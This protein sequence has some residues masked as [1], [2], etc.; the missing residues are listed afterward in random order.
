MGTPSRGCVPSYILE[1]ET[2][3]ARAG[4]WRRCSP[5]GSSRCASPTSTEA[6]APSGTFTSTRHPPAPAPRPPPRPHGECD[7][8]TRARVTLGSSTGATSNARHPGSMRRSPRRRLDRASRSRWRGRD[9]CRSRSAPRDKAR[10]G[11]ENG[12][13]PCGTGL[14]TAR[15]CRSGRIGSG[16]HLW[17]VDPGR[18]GDARTVHVVHERVHAQ[19]GPAG[20]QKVGSARVAETGP[21]LAAA[22]V[23]SDAIELPCPV[24]PSRADR[25]VPAPGSAG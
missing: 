13:A 9:G 14:T 12:L 20:S 11:H 5:L 16:Q 2:H 23:G 10:V 6:C 1:V 19:H 3:S 15:R 25:S 17:R 4:R 24:L 18:P 7:G 8:R 22:R 21:T